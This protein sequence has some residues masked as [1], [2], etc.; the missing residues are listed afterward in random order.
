M[1]NL[2]YNF[3]TDY[4]NLQ[5]SLVPII[6]KDVTTS[7]ITTTSWAGDIGL[8]LCYPDLEGSDVFDWTENWGYYID[9]GDGTITSDLTSY[10]AY[11]LP[12]R[13][14]I[15]LLMSDSAANITKSIY[16]QSVEIYNVIPDVLMFTYLS[17]NSATSS[18]L[19]I[20]IQITRFNSF[21]SYNSLSSIGY[22]VKLSVSGNKA[23]FKTY[24]DYENDI[25]S[26][27]KSFS[28]FISGTNQNIIPVE[29]VKTTVDLIY[30]WRNPY[31][32]Y[33]IDL[34]SDQSIVPDGYSVYFVGTSGIANIYYYEDFIDS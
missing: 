25:N 34:V 31:L 24:S 16:N 20:P 4:S 21:Q 9:W 27:L 1:P 6:V 18:T 28:A 3:T 15:T 7:T 11:E 23:K 33:G 29:N 30:A 8:L 32:N 5:N 17:G 13:Y 19:E 26:H 10:H 22:T 14:N 2:N 12:G